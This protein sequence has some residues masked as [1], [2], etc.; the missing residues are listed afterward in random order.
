[1]AAGSSAA[2][3]F[4]RA[5]AVVRGALDRRVTPAAVV[6]VGT[7]DHVWWSEAFGSLTYAAG[8]PPA[9]PGTIFDLASLTKVVATTTLVMRLV[10]AGALALGGRIGEWIACWRGGEREA[11]TLLDLLAHAAGLPDTRPLY[12]RASGRAAIERAVCEV[13]LE[14]AP[15]SA[16]RYSDLGFILLGFIVES[17]VGRTLATQF[18]DVASM[19]GWG[20]LQFGI[21]EGW[22]ERTAPTQVDAWRGRLLQGEVDDRNAAALGGIAG[23]SGLFGTA[24]GVGAFAR[25]ILAGLSGRPA[26]FPIAAGPTIARFTMAVGTPGSSRALGW[27]TMLPTSSCGARMSPEAF[28]HTGFTGT[29]LWIDPAAG[30]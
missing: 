12:E 15:R 29:S 8:S 24:A 17:A 13:P 27:D 25:S 11:V 18:E 26:P 20:E 6:E 3:R 16:S 10:E 30:V 2:A 21:A 7:P 9:T 1:M 23:H 22:R 5:R 19:A 14:Y 28:G 4:D